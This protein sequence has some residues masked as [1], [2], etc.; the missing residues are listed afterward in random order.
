M[1][2]PSVSLIRASLLLLGAQLSLAAETESVVTAGLQFLPVT[3]A[4]DQATSAPLIASVE[5]ALSRYAAGCEAYDENAIAEVFTSFAVIA[6]ASRVP[7]RFVATN[8][9]TAE[10]CWASALTSARLNKSP[11]WIYPTNE[12]NYVLI[13][14]AAI[15]GTGAAQH[16]VLDVALIEMAGDRIARIWDYALPADS[17]E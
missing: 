6:Y 11:I 2:K 8:A 13:Q 16:T 12:P 7:G 9:I 17:V 5:R 4:P 10:R 15:I 3:V 14:Y 1:N